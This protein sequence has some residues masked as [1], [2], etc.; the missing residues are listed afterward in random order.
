MDSNDSLAVRDDSAPLR[1]CAIMLSCLG[2]LL[3]AAPL[4]EWASWSPDPVQGSTHVALGA[5]AGAL[6]IVALGLAISLMGFQAVTQPT[7][8]HFSAMFFAALVAT[9]T[10]VGHCDHPRD[11]CDQHGECADQGQLFH[12][13]WRA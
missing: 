7:I 13:L 11:R 3:L 8:G 5:G 1:A 2:L 10:T 6:G 12:P 9:T 4:M